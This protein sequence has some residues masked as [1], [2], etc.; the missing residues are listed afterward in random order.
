MKFQIYGIFKKLMTDIT[1]ESIFPFSI[2]YYNRDLPR[3][4]CLLS[5]TVFTQCCALVSLGRRNQLHTF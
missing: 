2:K 4:V 1:I 5:H 3:V